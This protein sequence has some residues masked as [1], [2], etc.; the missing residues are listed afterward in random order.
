MVEGK[1]QIFVISKYTA[2]RL[3]PPAEKFSKPKKKETD[4]APAAPSAVMPPGAGGAFAKP[5]DGSQIPP[6][7]MKK[8]QAEIK[9]QKM[10]KALAN[11]P[12]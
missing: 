1:D 9:R 12:K 7:V 11:Q 5:T 10:M 3:K 4:G 8:L 2:E 6:D